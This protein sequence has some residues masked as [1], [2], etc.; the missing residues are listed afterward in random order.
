M[1]SPLDRYLESV[2]QIV[3]RIR[4]SQS[5]RLREAATICA[6]CI[7]A[8]G[9]VHVFASGHSRV[10]VEEMFPRYGSFVGFH[11]IVDLS[12]TYHTE[13]VGNNGQRQARFL[14]DV[15]GLGTVLLEN[16]VISP[17]DV[18]LIF[19]YSGLHAVGIDVALGAKSRGAD[20][21]RGCICGSVPSARL[22]AQQ[23]QEANRH[24]GRGSRHRVSAGRRDGGDR[25][26]G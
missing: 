24:R 1:S 4:V 3:D 14:E 21:H 17:P 9:L 26:N 8:E 16:F 18:M 5:G 10:S 12:L 7:A 23:W 2:L 22:V 25:R 11:P 15:E 6:D 19:S 20:R 13:V